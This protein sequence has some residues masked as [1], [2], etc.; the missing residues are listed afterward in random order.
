MNISG[1]V[2][3]TLPRSL[4]A[5]RAALSALPGTAI[6][7]AAEDGRLVVTVEELG[8]H[9]LAETVMHIQTMEGVL[10]A[11]MAYH[12]CDSEETEEAER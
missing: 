4:A 8:G 6:H 10:S 9:P 3:H 7:A 5:V 2:V 11:S 1:L 12:Y